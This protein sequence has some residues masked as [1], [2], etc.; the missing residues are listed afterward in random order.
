MALNVSFE[1][2]TVLPPSS[3]FD[4]APPGE[5]A[6]ERDDECRDIQI[7]DEQP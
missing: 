2:G 3:H 7:C 5:Q 4:T 1:T 6:A